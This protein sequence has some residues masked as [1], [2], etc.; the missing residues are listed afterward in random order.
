MGLMG[1]FRLFCWSNQFQ[2]ALLSL[3]YGRPHPQKM[4]SHSRSNEYFEG[5]DIKKKIQLIDTF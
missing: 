3:G 5:E 4:D 2:H 1:L